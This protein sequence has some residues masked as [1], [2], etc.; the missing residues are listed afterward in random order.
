MMKL[1]TARY[2][3]EIFL[4]KLMEEENVVLNLT[5]AAKDRKV[6]FPETMLEGIELGDLF[7]D[8]IQ[9]VT[10]AFDETLV[11]TYGMNDP[12]LE[13]LAPI[14]R[15]A[16]N[17]FCVGKNYKDHAI[18]M[19]SAADIPEFVMMF[20]KAPTAVIGHQAEILRHEKVTDELDYEGE[21]AVVIGKKGIGI[22]AE[23]AMDHI[24][25][26]TIIN[27]VT[28]RDL[29]K[30]HKQFL[31]GKSLDGSCPMGPC[32]VPKQD[33][34]DPH[35][36]KLTTTVNGEVRQDGN[37][38]DFIFTIPEIIEALSAG[39]TLEPGDIIA[40]GTPAGVGKGFKPPRLLNSGDTVEITV[41]GIGTL[42]NSVS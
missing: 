20:S 36:L 18:E 37:T 31:I 6:D 14:P 3:N 12:D 17:I 2:Q 28:A 26:Y 9:Q 19:G 24:F 23:E 40:T 27:D 7:L 29:Q 21:L 22:T 8:K 38:K 1:V 30:R 25:G 16:K 4:G 13:W 32:I 34:G 5:L 35:Q 15:P 42:R 10:E 33:I 41:E 11:F 39:T